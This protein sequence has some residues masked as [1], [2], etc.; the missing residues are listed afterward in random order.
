MR[1][2]RQGEAFLQPCPA[3]NVSRHVR[4]KLADVVFQREPT[5]RIGRD[6]PIN[7]IDIKSTLQILTYNTFVRHE[8]QN[9]GSVDQG[10]AQQQRLTIGRPWSVRFCR[11]RSLTVC[12][13]NTTSDEVAPVCVT[14]ASANGSGRFAIRRQNFWCSARNSAQAESPLTPSAD[15]L[16]QPNRT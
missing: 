5:I 1:V 15:W 4:E 10:V 7:H 12:V 6:P 9:I 3:N 8:I 14:P 11:Y 13:L 16:V 2:A